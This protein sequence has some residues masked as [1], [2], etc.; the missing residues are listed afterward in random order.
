MRFPGAFALLLLLAACVAPAPKPYE[1]VGFDQVPGWREDDLAAALPA[2]RRSCPKMPESWRLACAALPDDPERARSYFEGEFQAYRIG[3]TALVTGYYE[4]ELNGAQQPSARYRVPLHRPPA[5]L[6][7]VDL[8]DWRDTWRGER[9]AGRVENGRLRPYWRRAD[10]AKGVLDG[11]N[12][13][14][15]W[16]DDDVDAFFLEVQGSG[17]VRLEDGRLLRVGF[18]GQNGHRYVAIGRTLLDKG[19]LKPGEVSM[20]S[21]RAWLAANPDKMREI[22]DSNPSY[23]FFRILEGEGPLGAQGVALTPGR[24]LAVDRSLLPLGAPV[25]VD[26]LHPDSPGGRL[27]RLVVAQDTGGAIKGPARGDLFWGPGAEAG[28]IAGRMKAEGALY[29][30]LPRGLAPGA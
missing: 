29:L 10:I 27:R 2:L 28:E 8:G 23:V 11:K 21:I 25:F 7:Q 22:L 17:R 19:E 12:A 5:D 16:V 3:Q 14:L 4:P 26:L 18:A 6:V 20:Q 13:E 1:P 24:S 9:V 30:L 15:L